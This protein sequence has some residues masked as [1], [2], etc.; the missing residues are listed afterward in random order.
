LM[1]QLTGTARANS[2]QRDWIEW[3]PSGKP[4]SFVGGLNDDHKLKR[5][6]KVYNE[7]HLVRYEN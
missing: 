1:F 7:W 2:S 5:S 3:H 6:T 4:G